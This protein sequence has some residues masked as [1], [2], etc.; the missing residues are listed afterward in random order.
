M[1]LR[2][3]A[4]K[5]MEG[6][7]GMA[8]FDCRIEGEGILATAKLNVLLPGNVERFLAEKR[9]ATTLPPRLPAIR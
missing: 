6:A 3:S 5:L 1:A 4:E 2:V 9:V 7:N 8:V